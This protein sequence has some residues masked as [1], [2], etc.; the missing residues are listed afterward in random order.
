MLENVSIVS[1]RNGRLLGDT[2]GFVINPANLKIEAFKC[3][4]NNSK[5]PLFLLNQDV[6]DMS[7]N[8]IFINDDEV[9]SEANDLIRIKELIDL[10]FIIIG[11]IVITKSKQKLGKV[12]EF[13]V[14]N[15]SLFLQ[16]LYISQPI[17]KN[18]YGGQLIIDRS[19]IVE[20]TNTQIIVKDIL[21]PTKLK[22]AISSV[23]S[24]TGVI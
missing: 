17:Y 7:D 1:L 3:N 2:I 22:T 5:Q 12:K 16:K 20:V 21:Q 13:S 9:L 15:S 19:Q 6:R 14:D 23:G 18:I 10:N 8:K 24:I 11:K 4:I